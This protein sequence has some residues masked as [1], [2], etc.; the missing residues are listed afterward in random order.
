MG[1]WRWG[2]AGAWMSDNR[3]EETRPADSTAG[4]GILRLRVQ[5]PPRAC[6]ALLP[7]VV[8][9]GQRPGDIPAQG[10][11]QGKTA[12]ISPALKGRHRRCSAPSGLDRDGIVFP[13]RCPGLAC[14]RT[15]GAP[16]RSTPRCMTGS[17]A[18]RQRKLR[19][20]VVALTFPAMS[21][22]TEIE[23]AVT[24]L[25][26][27][28]QSE[29]LRFVAAHLRETAPDETEY[30]LSSPA[31]RDHLLRAVEDVAAGRNIVVPDQ[32]MFQ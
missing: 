13:G 6:H 23:T 20:A 26:R 28:E 21:T 22:L 18:G 31:N 32:A 7:V 12:N 17:S 3:R 14:L 25:P 24:L 2:K 1:Q 5:A 10:N 30:L 27:P 9:E 4:G 16:A 11:A 15:V 19:G 29:L 8:T